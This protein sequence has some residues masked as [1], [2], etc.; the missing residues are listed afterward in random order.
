MIIHENV[1][2]K[3]ITEYMTAD[4][5]PRNFITGLKYSKHENAKHLKALQVFFLQKDV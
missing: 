1:L 5:A 3:G 4:S 2:H